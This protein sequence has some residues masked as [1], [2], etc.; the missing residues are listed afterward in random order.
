MGIGQIELGIAHADFGLLQGCERDRI[1]GDRI[2][3]FTLADGLCFK[4]DVQALFFA[5]GL[6]H[7][8]LLLGKLR[9]CLRHGILIG[10]GVNQEH[11]LSRFDR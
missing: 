11:G 3:I 9:L 2:I 10:H 8:G 5:L 6:N 1:L 4:Q 7:P